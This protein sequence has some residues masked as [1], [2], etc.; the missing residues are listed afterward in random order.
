MITL[1]R[2]RLSRWLLDAGGSRDLA[3]AVRTSDWSADD[4]E[5]LIY[6]DRRL[7]VEA[8]LQV[9]CCPRADEAT[10]DLVERIGRDVGFTSDQ[11]E[12]LVPE[13]L[14]ISAVR[15]RAHA[16][17]GLPLH[18]SADE[19]KATHR[20]IAKAL[21][22]D[23]LR[24]ADDEA[25]R[26]AEHLLGRINHARATLLAPGGIVRSGPDDVPLEAALEPPLHRGGRS[27]DD[28]ILEDALFEDLESVDG[29]ADPT[30][31]TDL[32]DL[33]EPG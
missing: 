21:H 4:W 10:L 20:T 23:R 24:G 29:A 5:G 16:V 15:L 26:A 25:R 2:E 14:G 27:P 19:I 12:G 33:L 18:A 17:L 1:D 31:D 22:P 8:L 3:R 32:T 7:L 9:F 30:T 28:V 6:D 13:V 11:I